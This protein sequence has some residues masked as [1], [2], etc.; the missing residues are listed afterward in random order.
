MSGSLLF[1]QKKEALLK[2]IAQLGFSTIKNANALT[3]VMISHHSELY[4]PPTKKLGAISH[5]LRKIDA[6][7]L[8]GAQSILPNLA[9]K[10]HQKVKKRSLIVLV[11]DFLG[12]V[13]LSLLAKRHVLYVIIIRDRFEEN[14][15]A[16]GDGEFMD[17]QTLEKAAFYFGKKAK[18]AY[19]KRYHDNDLKLI[20]HLQMLGIAY[21]KVVI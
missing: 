1:K 5:F 21:D 15:H 8:E 10:I 3:P 2:M 19:A 4:L 16:L 11:G 18:E 6:V 13:D 14:P 17:P 12:E 9:Q 7:N 20:R